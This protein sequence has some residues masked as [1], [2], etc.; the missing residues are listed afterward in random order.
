MRFLFFD[1]SDIY[2]CTEKSEVLECWKNCKNFKIYF[3][4]HKSLINQGIQAN[5]GMLETI[6]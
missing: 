2:Q 5:V 1:V 6:L 4:T 3:P